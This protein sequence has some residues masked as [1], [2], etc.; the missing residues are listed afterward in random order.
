M[1]IPTAIRAAR[2]VKLSAPLGVTQLDKK[3]PLEGE[4]CL[5]INTKIGR[6][7]LQIHDKEVLENERSAF[8]TARIW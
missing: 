1:I 3:K 7:A 6:N 2:K 5:N 4:M 8:W